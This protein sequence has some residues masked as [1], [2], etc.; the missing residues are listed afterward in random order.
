MHKPFDAVVLCEVV[1]QPIAMLIQ[2]LCQIGCYTNVE[3]S[4]SLTG[5]DVD[6]TGLRHISIICVHGSPP[7]RDDSKCTKGARS[8]EPKS[9]LQSL[10]RISYA[11]FCFKKKKIK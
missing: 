8:E 7:S 1:N 2:S 11:V 3:G 10:L 6:E 9:E 4:M 5:E